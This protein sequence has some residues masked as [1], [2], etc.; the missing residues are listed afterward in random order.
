MFDVCALFVCFPVITFV[1]FPRSVSTLCLLSAIFYDCNLVQTICHF[2][3]LNVRQGVDAIDGSFRVSRPSHSHIEVH[4]I[5]LLPSKTTLPDR[6]LFD[7][8]VPD[9]SAG[10]SLHLQR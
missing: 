7:N 10:P 5:S 8:S 3:A 2:Q 9:C 1:C 4:N 6:S